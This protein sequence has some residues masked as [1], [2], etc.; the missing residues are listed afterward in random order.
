MIKR[1]DGRWQ[2]QV[3]LPGMAKPKYFYGRTQKEVLQK[4]AE[5]RGEV[6][7]GKLFE[8]CVDAWEEWHEEH[9]T[10][11]AALAYKSSI[12]Q[13]KDQFGG[14]SIKEI[15]PDEIDA[16][17]RWLAGRG[18]ARRTVQMRLD[19]L[20]MVFDYAVVHLWR[21][22]NPCASVSL[23]R[24]LPSK[25]RDVPSDEQMQAIVDAFEL[26]FGL[27][28][29]C[30]V[31]SGMRRGELLGLRWEDIDQERDE[32]HV[33]RSV[34]FVHNAPHVKEPKTESGIRTVP[35]LAPLK[36]ALAGGG[37]GYVFH[38]DGDPERPLSQSTVAI[39][40]RIWCRAAGIAHQEDGV[41][42]PDVTPHQLRHE[43]ATTLY[44]AGVEVGDAKVLMGHSC[45]AVTRDIYTHIRQSRRQAARERINQYLCQ[46][47][48]GD[49]ERG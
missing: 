15:R 42:K 27:F 46:K 21:D 38:A 29:R 8:D 23:P 45:E 26:P 5:Y 36:G 6:E 32:I 12:K 13:V 34:Y 35:L 4:I 16:F 31:Y 44:D 14:R 1:K 20:N 2:E 30:L 24:G 33:R 41:W 39:R 9:V 43:Y 19:L 40:W 22:N 48:V 10:Y 47:A 3:K 28:A 25:R 18:Y 37:R 7:R 11:N 17:V 49:G